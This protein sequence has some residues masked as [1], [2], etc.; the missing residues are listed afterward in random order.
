MGHDYIELM[1]AALDGRLG[2]SERAEWNA[3]LHNCP[4]CQERWNALQSIDRL[5]AS[6]PPAAPAPGFAAR[7]MARVEKRQAAQPVRQQAFAGA[8]VLTTGAILIL[9]AFGWLLAWQLP[10]LSKTVAGAPTFLTDVIQSAIRWFVLIR[11]LRET[12]LALASF[13]PPWGLALAV[14]Y[15]GLLVA[16]SGVWSGI[17]LRITRPPSPALMVRDV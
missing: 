7:V 17:V 5:F 13:I 11:A 1:S 8:G 9:V 3:H 6:A 15:I 4:R 12:G 2:A 14:G 10:A 16:L